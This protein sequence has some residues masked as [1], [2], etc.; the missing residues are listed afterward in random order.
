MQF[1][2]CNYSHGN[3]DLLYYKTFPG[4]ATYI[5][6]HPR[7]RT[8]DKPMYGYH[9]SPAWWSMVLLEL[10]R[11]AK[12]KQRH[13]YQPSPPQ[14]EWQITKARNLGHTAHSQKAALQLGV[15]FSHDSAAPNLLQALSLIWV[16]FTVWP[17]R[18]SSLQLGLCDWLSAAF[19]L[20]SWLGGALMNPVSFRDFL[21]LFWVIICPNEF[22]CRMK[23]FN[24]RGNCYSQ[25]CTD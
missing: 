5:N 17:S 23:C 19:A 21:K 9:Q 6:T 8:H 12:M 2:A 22:L 20:Y 11:A 4:K 25:D 24:F 16:F 14:P 13:L 7:Y 18:E 3:V 15:S 1:L 10:L